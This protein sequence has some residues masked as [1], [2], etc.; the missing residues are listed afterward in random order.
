[1][2]AKV[3]SPG[4]A[5]TMRMAARPSK[6]LQRNSA[7]PFV[8]RAF[9]SICD[10]ARRRRRARRFHLLTRPAMSRRS[11]GPAPLKRDAISQR[12]GC[13]DARSTDCRCHGGRARGVRKRARWVQGSTKDSSHETVLN[14]ALKSRDDIAIEGILGDHRAKAAD[15]CD[16]VIRWNKTGFNA[17]PRHWRGTAH[18]VTTHCYPCECRM[19]SWFED[20]ADVEASAKCLTLECCWMS[21]S[22]GSR[23][24]HRSRVLRHGP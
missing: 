17:R 21:V 3:E 24:H 20:V 13:L 11:R 5:A 8:S 6:Y 15:R 7:A 22:D 14:P 19:S 10:A 16:D 2:P 18:S 4:L 9:T 12:V 23:P 1:M